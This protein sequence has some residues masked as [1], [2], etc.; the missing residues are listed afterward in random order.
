MIRN[1]RSNAKTATQSS[2]NASKVFPA[3]QD[4]TLSAASS[5]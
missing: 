1:N 2:E 5:I 4:T 3:H